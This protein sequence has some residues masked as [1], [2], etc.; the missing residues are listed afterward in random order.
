MSTTQFFFYTIISV[1]LFFIISDLLE[2]FLK[3]IKAK[4]KAEKI[5]QGAEK[6]A[7]KI[8]QGA[9]EK[10]YER[11]E[12]ARNKFQEKLINLEAKYKQKN[13]E[14][15]KEVQALRGKVKKIEEE[16]I[17]AKKQKYDPRKNMP[18]KKILDREVK[19][20]LEPY[21]RENFAL[22]KKIEFL[23]IQEQKDL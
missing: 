13:I 7:E 22:K 4:K 8:I 15:Q 2:P 6:K 10:A 16:L 1:L 9:E 19:R 23:K 17:L 20:A 3:K 5:I 11:K 21:V 12:E 18:K 14:R